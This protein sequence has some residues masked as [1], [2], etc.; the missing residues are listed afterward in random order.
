[1]RLLHISDTHNFHRQLDNLPKAD[2]LIHSG[3]VSMAGTGK[4]VVD[5]IEWF[6]TLDYQYKIFIAGNHDFCLEGKNREVIQR[7]LPDSCFYLY[8]S[9]VSIEGINFWGLPFFFTYDDNNQY[10]KDL[11]QIPIN[12]DVIIS[13]RPPFGI[14]DNAAGIKYGCKELLKTV[15]TIRP[16]YHLFGH[17]HNSYGIEKTEHTTFANASLVDD[18]YRLLNSPLIFGI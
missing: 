7:F 13:H 4:E 16:R 1:M 9:S 14:L 10:P 11:A 6:G 5:F 3:D 18:K 15:S 17:I 12:T 2:V 8:N